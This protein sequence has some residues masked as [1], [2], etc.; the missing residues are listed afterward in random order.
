MIGDSVWDNM[1][2]IGCV[3]ALYNDTCNSCPLTRSLPRLNR[4]FY[5][6]KGKGILKSA[7]NLKNHSNETVDPPLYIL[8]EV[9]SVFP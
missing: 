7:G 3:K 5:Q 8:G 9:Y 4:A 6:N 2:V 1:T